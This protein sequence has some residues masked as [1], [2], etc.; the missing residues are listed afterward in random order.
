MLYRAFPIACAALALTLVL[1]GQSVTAG[2]K[3]KGV[4]DTTHEGKVVSVK[5]G[6]L[7]MESKGKEHTHDVPATAK[8]TCDGK[9][10]KLTDLKGGEFVR[11]TTDD[12]NRATVIEARR[13]NSKD[14]K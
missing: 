2:D 14:K 1:A 5:E 11:V 9:A 3:D 10:C 4:K 12:A 13:S 8:I 6:K 7:T